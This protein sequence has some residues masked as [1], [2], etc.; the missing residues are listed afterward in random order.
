MIFE[1]PHTIASR[2]E[3][4]SNC[5]TSVKSKVFGARITTCGKIMH[6]TDISCGCIVIGGVLP[7]TS[8]KEQSCPQNKW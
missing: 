5:P 8:L 3:I 6:P 7:K 1:T 2:I 4:C